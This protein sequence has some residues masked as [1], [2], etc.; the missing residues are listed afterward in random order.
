MT[1]PTGFY[2]P[3]THPVVVKGLSKEETVTSHAL[4][5]IGDHAC[6]HSFFLELHSRLNELAQ[7]DWSNIRW[8]QKRIA[9]KMKKV[10]KSLFQV[11]G[12][13]HVNPDTDGSEFITIP[14][15]HLTISEESIR[16][17]STALAA[18]NV[19]AYI[20]KESL[21]NEA[22]NEANQGQHEAKC[23]L[24]ASF[25]KNCSIDFFYVPE[26][27]TIAIYT[28]IGD[29]VVDSFVVCFSTLSIEVLLVAMNS[30]RISQRCEEILLEFFSH[31]RFIESYLKGARKL[32]VGSAPGEN[33]TL[34]RK[35]K[36]KENR[37]G[38]KCNVCKNCVD[39]TRN[40][41]CSE[42]ARRRLAEMEEKEGEEEDED[43]EDTTI[44]NGEEEEE[45]ES[46]DH[47]DKRAKT[48]AQS[49]AQSGAKS[50]E[51][52]QETVNEDQTASEIVAENGAPKVGTEV[53]TVAVQV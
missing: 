29:V 38:P 7:S 26:T 50:D 1:T 15:L 27:K 31:T 47:Q 39:P 42:R 10:F 34:K 51:Q 17:L 2:T 43:T 53:N 40:K 21:N 16:V 28:V 12:S 48:D 4:R 44:H 11:S 22:P 36:V 52:P 14:S 5:N 18:P 9:I 46:G 13:V 20:S 32:T 8:L 41:M 30:T 35:R 33:V 49:D 23:M 6:F 3:L 45:E 37:Y 24:L 25:G 19:N